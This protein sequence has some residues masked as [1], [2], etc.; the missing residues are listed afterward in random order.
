MGVASTERWFETVTPT[1]SQVI[2]DLLQMSVLNETRETFIA[3]VR[4]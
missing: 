1:S 4:L 3:A 2:I